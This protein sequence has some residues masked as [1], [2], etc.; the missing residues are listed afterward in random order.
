MR[1][2]LAATPATG[3]LNPILAAARVLVAQGHEVALTTASAFRAKVEA[4][5]A[6][7]VPLPPGAD[8]DLS[9]TAGLF[10]ERANLQPGLP[11]LAFDFKHFFID[12]IP[13]Q[14]AGLERLLADF[15]AD[16]ILAD[17]MFGGCLPFLL[18]A[19]ARRPAIATLGVSSLLTRRRDRAPVGMG[20]PP[21]SDEITVIRYANM[22]AEVNM[23]LLDPLRLQ[24]DAVLK[25]LGAQSLPMPYIEALVGLPDLFLQPSVPAFDFPC[26]ELP[27]NLHFIGALPTSPGEP[28]PADLAAA[29]GAGR[30]VVL[31][32][33]GTVANHDLGQ[34]IGPTV[35]ALAG[36]DDVLLLIATGGRPLEAIPHPLPANALAAAFLPF[37]A[38]MPHLD[39][40][41]TNGGHGGVTQA[42][43]HGVPLVTAGTSEDKREVNAR[44]GWSGVGLDLR[45]DAP[46]VAQLRD[47]IASVLD[48]PAYRR[49]AQAMAQAFAGYDA[50]TLLCDLLEQTVRAHPVS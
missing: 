45:T 43:T 20:L 18:G 12:P 3:H 19:R 13:A 25:A 27:P 39:L 26:M 49:R 9:D 30:R 46:S 28:L 17:T 31:V 48:D 50:A 22:A 37:D 34:L 6:R 29:I 47:A 16:A 42:V 7:F 21:A 23:V 4:T 38:L 33:Q 40:F 14:F 1:I 11:Q 41:V 32:T 35:Q 5:G 24:V 10:P 8:M 15:P 36:R 2:I 44:V